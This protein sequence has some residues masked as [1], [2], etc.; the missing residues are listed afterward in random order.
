[1]FE[2]GFIDIERRQAIT[3]A[4]GLRALEDELLVRT[5]VG[6]DFCNPLS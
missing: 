1:M 4:T 6:G 3:D 2:F 5:D